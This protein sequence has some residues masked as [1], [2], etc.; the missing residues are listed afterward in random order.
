VNLGAAFILYYGLAAIVRF[1]KLKKSILFI[2]CVIYSIFFI[3]VNIKWYYECQKDWYKQLAFVEMFKESD[4]IKN[5]TT[6]YFFDETLEDN[7]NR[8][9][10]DYEFNG[11]LKLAFNDERRLCS[12]NRSTALFRTYKTTDFYRKY[13]QYN[14]TDWIP[15]NY[16]DYKIRIKYGEQKLDIR[17]MIRLFFSRI[18][19]KDDFQ[20]A[21]KTLYVFEYEESGDVTRQ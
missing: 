11:L 4:I 2:I 9:L 17:L 13:K 1:L 21:L 8:Y 20:K 14:S 15:K 18:V 12:A 3:G 5:N 19:C 6:F 16:Y 7:V 10:Y